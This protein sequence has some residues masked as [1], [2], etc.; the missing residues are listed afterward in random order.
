[1]SK[2]TT[3]RKKRLITTKKDWIVFAVSFLVV[4]FGVAYFVTDMCATLTS[5]NYYLDALVKTV[6]VFG[7]VFVINRV[8]V[9]ILSININDDSRTETIHLMF[10]SFIKYLIA[11]ISIIILLIIWL[12]Q[13]YVSNILT[14]VGVL[15]LIIGLGAQSLINDILA[16]LFLVFEN[17]INVGDVVS[18]GSWRGTVVEIGIRTTVLVDLAGNEKIV[19]NS[20]ITEFINLT[21][22]LSVAA[23]EI[24]VDYSTPVE[25]LDKAVNDSL[26][27]LQKLI[28]EIVEGPTY[29]GITELSDSAIFFKVIAKVKEED[30][31]AV[32]RSMLRFYKQVLDDNDIRIPFN[33]ITISNRIEK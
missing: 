11:I 15:A 3:K 29:L 12:G 17:H 21:N 13:E 10:A 32:Q 14:G 16:G 5:I 25:K 27:D 9:L 31:F 19:S 2:G 24:G 23:V 7:W 4:S 28:P 8:S 18:I 33:Q 6:L 26:K 20:S 30:R 22:E 1:M